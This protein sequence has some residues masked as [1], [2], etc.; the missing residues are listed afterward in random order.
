[1][2][3][4]NL[5]KESFSPHTNQYDGYL[6]H[7]TTTEHVDN[8]LENGFDEGSY[9]GSYRIAEFYAHS[10]E[11]GS[12]KNNDVEPV[13]IAVPI[14]YFNLNNLEIDWNSYDEPITFTLGM[15]ED[16]LEEMWEES[17]KSVE[18]FYEIYE[19][20]VY[21]KKLKGEFEEIYL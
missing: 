21:G 20:V 6:Y 5:L 18:S 7:G 12:V 19:S 16:E 1:M 4:K 2:S 3:L 14:K 11:E 9:F 8:I 15:K 10:I 13:I 17:D